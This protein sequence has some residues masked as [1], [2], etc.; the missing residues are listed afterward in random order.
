[1]S[2][3]SHL[4][5]AHVV[6][7][8]FV[9]CA[10]IM[11]TACGMPGGPGKAAASPAPAPSC[12][13]TP[14]T[15]TTVSGITNPGPYT[16]IHSWTSRLPEGWTQ[17]KESTLKS[18]YS[19]RA[20]GNDA[21]DPNLSSFLNVTSSSARVGS[22]ASATLDSEVKK[23]IT[24]AEKDSY[25]V[26]PKQVKCK[27]D[28]DDAVA[29]WESKTDSGGKLWIYVVL[30]IHRGTYF[31]D[32]SATTYSIIGGAYESKKAQLE[33]GVK[34]M[35]ARWTWLPAASGAVTSSDSP[36]PGF[37]LKTSLR[38]KGSMEV[39]G[40]MSFSGTYDTTVQVI[41]AGCS[42]LA[43]T[44]DLDPSND[45]KFWPIPPIDDATIAGHTLHF[46]GLLYYKTYGTFQ[47]DGSLKSQEPSLN[48]RALT[49]DGKSFGLDTASK[50]TADIKSDASGSLNFT[51][52][53]DPS[54]GGTVS[55]STTWVCSSP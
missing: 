35:V 2:F 12:S 48:A 55:G 33:K 16:P 25:K 26:D 32:P 28:G 49:I 9:A 46:A 3:A 23:E 53:K 8:S 40:A 11:L 47:I 50:A 39:H 17:S 15:G 5:S 27:V 38:L 18:P 42:G 20:N 1:M 34:G 36:S 51:N 19:L 29:L 4:R 52:L 54:S 7:L 24:S 30:F 13:G 21:S 31:G 10:G 37:S 6:R 22:I 45:L 44:G 43:K 41:A 14:T